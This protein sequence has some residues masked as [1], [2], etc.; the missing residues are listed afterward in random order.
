MQTSI[1]CSDTEREIFQLVQ[2]RHWIIPLFQADIMSSTELQPFGIAFG[3]SGSSR[4]VET[5]EFNFHSI[6]ADYETTERTDPAFFQFRIQCMKFIAWAGTMRA[7][8]AA[9]CASGSLLTEPHLQLQLFDISAPL[10]TLVKEAAGSINDVRSLK[11]KY[12]SFE[13]N[14]PSDGESAQ[15]RSAFILYRSLANLLSRGRSSI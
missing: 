11:E 9:A 2:S 5:F 7:A 10:F 6:V 3:F 8:W 14:E 1:Q 13:I 15:L 4:L 12:G